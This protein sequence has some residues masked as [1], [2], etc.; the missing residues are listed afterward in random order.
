MLQ[1]RPRADQGRRG[2]TEFAPPQA[3]GAEQKVKRDR[4]NRPLILQPDGTEVGYTRMT[5]LAKIIDD[6]TMLDKWKLRN[7]MLGMV[8][9]PDL[10]LAVRAHRDDKR[11]LNQLAE[12]A[13]EAAKAHAKATIGTAI[14][15]LSEA[16]DR[17][18]SL[19][20]VPPE[21]IP[22][23]AAY[24]RLMTEFDVL[25]SEEFR[26]VDS[27][28]CAGTADRRVRRKADGKVYILDTKTGGI[29]L[30]ALSIAS[31]LAGYAH[32]C[33]YNVE[34]GERLSDGADAPDTER[35]IVLHLPQDGS[36]A[37]LQWIDLET[38][39]EALQLCYNAHRIRKVKAEQ[40][41]TPLRVDEVI[42]EPDPIIQLILAATSIEELRGIWRVHYQVWTET[43]TRIAAERQ[44]GLS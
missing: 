33:R 6:T 40:L 5:T 2:R 31:Q 28:T 13:M 8:E 24:S 37:S 25:G 44:A 11:Q 39:W 43:H 17:G 3:L 22:V 10:L 12:D 35:G 23:L 4:W 20:G 15:A 1:G 30:G 26:V 38:G 9:R 14:H 27:L 34:T 18:E 42:E 29:E 7:V 32:G 36:P 19:E 21:W 16:V 41:L